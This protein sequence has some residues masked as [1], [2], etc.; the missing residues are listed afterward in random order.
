MGR[1]WV[2]PDSFQNRYR[3]LKDLQGLPSYCTSPNY[4]FTIDSDKPDTNE[5]FFP[6]V[7]TTCPLTSVEGD[8][9]GDQKYLGGRRFARKLCES[10]G[11]TSFHELFH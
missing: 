8:P 1:V 3:A 9:R 4:V 2:C 10:Q 11:M 7:V 5:Q 6:L